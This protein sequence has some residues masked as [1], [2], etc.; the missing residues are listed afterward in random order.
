VAEKSDKR[1]FEE[2]AKRLA[3]E[4][5]DREK[6]IP[7]LR[8]QSRRQYLSKR[9]DDKLVELQDDIAGTIYP[10]PREVCYFF[11]RAYVN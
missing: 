4:T 7:E 2:A 11:V 8:K 5:E 9:K 10:F 1:A 6:L 3:Q